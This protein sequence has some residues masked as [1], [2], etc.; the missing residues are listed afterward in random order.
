MASDCRKFTPMFSLI[1]SPITSLT[2]KNIPCQTALDTIKQAITNNPVLIY[3]DPNKQYHMF[4]NASNHTWSGLLTQTR[5]TLRENG[6]LDLTYHPIM[7]QSGTFTLSQINWSTVV[8]EVYAIMMSF[9]KMA[10]YL[11]MQRWSSDQIMTPLQKLI[12][13]KTK[14]VL[15]QNWALEIFSIS[16]HITFQHIKGKDNIIAESLSHLQC[17]GLYGKSPP[18]KSLV[19]NIVLQYLIQKTNLVKNMVLQY[20]M[21]VKPSRNMCNQKTSHLKIQIW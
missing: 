17:L 21:K 3:P 11:L 19:K 9:H 20:L 4:T 8:K 16:P 6:K 2:K 7:Y 12:K 18:E 5:E 1:V 15:T 10:F 13:N 14:N